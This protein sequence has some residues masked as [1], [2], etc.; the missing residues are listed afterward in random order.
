MVRGDEPGFPTY[1]ST[2]HGQPCRERLGGTAELGNIC[3]F[4]KVQI[5]N[6]KSAI[7]ADGN[8]VFTG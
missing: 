3:Q 4:S 2:L 7:G 5:W 6:E 1:G 8:K